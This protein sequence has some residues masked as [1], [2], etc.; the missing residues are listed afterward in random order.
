MFFPGIGLFIL[1]AG[2]SLGLFIEENS[3]SARCLSERITESV[4]NFSARNNASEVFSIASV[5][6][7]GAITTLGASPCPALN[8]MSKSDCAV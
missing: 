5:G 3:D 8:A 1:K 2:V 6:F 4:L 7:P